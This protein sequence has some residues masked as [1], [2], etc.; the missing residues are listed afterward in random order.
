M[1]AQYAHSIKRVT[2]SGTSFTGAEIWST[3]FYVG[4]VSADVSNP[5]QTF[6]DAVR[7]AWTTFFTSSAAGINP[8]W[9][10]DN[11]KVAQ[12]SAA[13]VTSLSNVV[14]APYG[15]AI[16]GG[17]PSASFPPQIA[18]VASLENSG[19]RGLAAKGRMCLPGVAHVVA[20]NGQVNTST[21][22][23]MVTALQTFINAVNTAAPTGEKVILASQ[24]NRVKGEDGKYTPVPGTATN[25]FVNRIR[26]GSVYD[27]QRRRRNAMVETYQSATIT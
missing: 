19:A 10:T 2:I 1:T 18:M 7:T 4:A 23:P 8:Q 14:Y 24:G 16:A 15:T 5:T 22:T 6:A 26:I 21:I 25:A 11:V 12:I 9:K 17:G 13:G 20:S 3:G 27:T